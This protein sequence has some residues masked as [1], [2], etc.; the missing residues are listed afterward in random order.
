MMILPEGLAGHCLTVIRLLQP[1]GEGWSGV[2]W[3]WWWGGWISKEGKKKERRKR[4]ASESEREKKRNLRKEKPP[5]FM[6][7]KPH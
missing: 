4:A 7:T 5:S 2:A 6:D 1:C 3:Q